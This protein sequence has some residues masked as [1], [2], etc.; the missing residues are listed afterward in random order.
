MP[1]ESSAGFFLYY[2]GMRLWSNLALILG[3]CCIAPTAG[4]ADDDHS[5]LDAERRWLTAFEKHDTA[6]LA[7]ILADNFVHINYRGQLLNRDAAIAGAK[8]RMPYKQL[9][10]D[11]T[12]QLAG[13]AAVV[14][15]INSI[16]QNGTVVLR[17]RF[18]DVFER[19]GGKWLAI[20]AQETPI[21]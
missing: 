21:Q 2:W 17:L 13:N 16:S 18:T 7:T 20:S 1:A 3:L 19:R 14:H 4:A 9:L 5:V 8:N 15:G 12:V 6:A 11:E 10:S